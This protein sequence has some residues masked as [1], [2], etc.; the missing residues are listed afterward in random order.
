MSSDGSVRHRVREL[1]GEDGSLKKV[2]GGERIGEV[3]F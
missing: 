2:M 3:G 1:V